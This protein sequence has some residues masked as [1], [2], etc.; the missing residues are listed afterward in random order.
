METRFG[1]RIFR[2]V[3][4]YRLGKPRR[5]CEDNIKMD[6]KETWNVCI[7][8]SPGLRYSPMFGCSAHGS[9]TSD[10]IK[11]VEFFDQLSEYHLNG[12]VS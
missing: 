5:I 10:F 6:L 9:K 11:G 4:G 7:L 2:S 1:N 3:L 12:T 8:D